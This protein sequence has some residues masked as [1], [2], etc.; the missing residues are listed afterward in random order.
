MKRILNYLRTNCVRI[1][2]TAALLFLA[3]WWGGLADLGVIPAAV[4]VILWTR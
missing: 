1:A 3:S 2:A 4:A